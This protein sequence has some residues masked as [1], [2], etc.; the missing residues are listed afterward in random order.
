MGECMKSELAD[1]KV[2]LDYIKQFGTKDFEKMLFYYYNYCENVSKEVLENRKLLE[3]KM[4]KIMYEKCKDLFW[5][6]KSNNSNLVIFDNDFKY[7]LEEVKTN[8]HNINIYIENVSKL[9]RLNVNEISLY[10]KKENF[11]FIVNSDLEKIN[12][13]KVNGKWYYLKEPILDQIRKVYTD[14]QINFVK[15][16]IFGQGTIEIPY[17]ICGGYYYSKILNSNWILDVSNKKGE[18]KNHLYLKNSFN[19]DFSNFP[20]KEEIESFEIPKNLKLYHKKIINHKSK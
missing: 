14:G 7:L 8:L 5:Y 1:Y 10:S 12:S 13:Y 15:K 4:L 20:N 2:I 11:S 18:I 17:F 9:D 16:N 3:K 19:F 6:L